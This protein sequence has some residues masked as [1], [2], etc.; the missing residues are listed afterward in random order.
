MLQVS[1]LKT[2]DG[3][4]R[5]TVLPEFALAVLS[6]P[7]ADG[8][9][10][11][12][13]SNVNRVKTKSRNRLITPTVEGTLLTS[14]TVKSA[15][16]CGE[17]E[18][19]S[20]MLNRMSTNTLYADYGPP[21]PKLMPGQTHEGSIY[22]EDL[23]CFSRGESLRFF[24]YTGLPLPG[25]TRYYLSTTRYYLVLPGTNK[26]YQVLPGTTKYYQVL[27][28]TTMYYLVLP[29]TTLYYHVLPLHYHVF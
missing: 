8:D 24:V 15:G 1:N 27:P 9:C 16:C 21:R 12:I 17:F 25:T 7:H 29:C 26:Y 22:D 6:L 19:T 2:S 14:Q 18:P 28:C 3:E 10:E 4:A 20:D 5:Y 23:A 11:R 13:F